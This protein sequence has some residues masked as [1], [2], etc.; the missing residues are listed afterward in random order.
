ML[1]V[2][3]SKPHPLL[4]LLLKLWILSQLISHH[5]PLRRR[6]PQRRRAASF[7][8]LRRRLHPWGGFFFHPLFHLR[9]PAAAT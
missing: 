6:L 1:H 4:E 9:H 5:P 2:P 3:F 8:H 7:S